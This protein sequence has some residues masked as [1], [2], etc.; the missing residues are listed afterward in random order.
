MLSLSYE[1]SFLFVICN[2]M[3]RNDTHTLF[4]M[5]FKDELKVK[6]QHYQTIKFTVC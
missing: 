1:L 5:G 4:Q 6:W 2:D 3:Q